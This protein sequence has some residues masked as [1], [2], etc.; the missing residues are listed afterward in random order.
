MKTLVSMKALALIHL[1]PAELAAHLKLAP[2]LRHHFVAAMQALLRLRVVGQPAPE[3][4]V[5]RGVL[6]TRPLPGGLDEAFVG[7]EGDVFHRIDLRFALSQC[8]HHSCDQKPQRGQ[9]LT[10]K[11]FELKT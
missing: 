7:A 2:Q 5:E 8:T 9:A 3:L 4:L 1:F 6:G 10:S 11:T